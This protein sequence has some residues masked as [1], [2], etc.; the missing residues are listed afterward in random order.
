MN[1]FITNKRPY[2]NSRKANHSFFGKCCS[3]SDDK[4]VPAIET[5]ITI[6]DIA[7]FINKIKSVIY[8]VNPFEILET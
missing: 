1:H 6:K 7:V 2:D 8:N 4:C 5:Q 3:L